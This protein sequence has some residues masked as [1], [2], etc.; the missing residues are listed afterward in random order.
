MFQIYKTDIKNILTNWVTAVIISGLIFL[1]SLYAWFNIYASMD[2]YANTANMKIAIVNE[3]TGA[4]VNGKDLN[5]GNEI[6]TNL[7]ANENFSW[8]F[9][10]RAE[11]LDQLKDGDYFAA[12]IVPNDFS[13]NLTSIM[14]DTPTKAQIDYYVNEKINPIAPKITSKGASV[15]RDQISSEFVSTVNGT[16][17][18]IFNT[19][20]IEVEKQIPDINKFENYIFSI[21]QHLPEI[22]SILT[23]ST[24]DAK[25]ALKLV[26]GA[27]AQIPEVQKVTDTGLSSI[28][29]GLTLINKV[30]TMLQNLSPIVIE[31]SATIQSIKTNFNQ[32]LEQLQNMPSNGTNVSQIQKQLLEAQQLVNNSIQSMETLQKVTS[33]ESAAREQLE[34]SIQNTITQLQQNTSEEST[35]LETNKLIQQLQSVQKLLQTNS[36]LEDYPSKSLTQLNQLK[37]LLTEVSN[38]VQQLDTTNGSSESI[39]ND[40]AHLQQVAQNITDH[41]DQ[42]FN[43]YVN[44]FETQINSTLAGAKNTLTSASTMLNKVQNAIP[45]ATQLLKN[46]QGTL[47]T[48]SNILDQ[49]QPNIPTLNKKIVELAEELRTLNNEADITEIVQL[50]KNDVNAERDFF[51]EP[52][53]LEEHRMFPIANYGTSMTPFYTVLAIWVG[54]LL[55]ISLLAVDIHHGKTYS[56]REVYFGRLLT[57]ATLSFLQTIIIST[58]DILLLDGSISAPLYF[59]LFSLFISFVFVT[60]VYTLVTV[61]GNIGKALAIVMLVLQIAG[62]GG[63]YPVEL[64][65]KFFQIINPFLPFTYAIEMMREAVGGIIWG[66]VF[67]DMGVMLFVWLFFILFGYFFKK[68]L[69][70]KM[71]NLMRKSRES[72]IF[73]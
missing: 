42:F 51:E 71:E 66:K 27:L 48:A 40:I 3:D 26:N 68:L 2:P 39:K 21:E 53:K 4:I 7:A 60:I 54:C 45:Q 6:I 41:L 64:L 5:V 8:H 10:S 38:N 12:I 67:I 14:T 55:L 33:T 65:P 20:G 31:N 50:L 47:S 70:E 62:S 11:A 43:D 19:V 61:F 69:S 49:V 35:Q 56:I 17:F 58:G 34:N 29:S 24:N 59:V 36:N 9:I 37:S 46:T 23:Q 63:T 28:D 44:Q 57:F 52:I 16:I 72:N 32:L 13:Q 18:D 15:I 22:E 25:A 1:P 30:D 73:H